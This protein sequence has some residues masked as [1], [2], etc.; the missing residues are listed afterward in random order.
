MGRNKIPLERL[1]YDVDLYGYVDHHRAY[2]E[3]GIQDVEPTCFEDVVG[4]VHWQNAM[5]EKMIMLNVN[6]T[7]ELV[8]WTED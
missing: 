2:M 1:T 8:P 4:N 5:D 3:K 6:G 7:W